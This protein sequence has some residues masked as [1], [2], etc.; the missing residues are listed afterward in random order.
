[1]YVELLNIFFL[2]SLV[3]FISYSLFFTTVDVPTELK[4]K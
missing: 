4:H 2:Y 3:H 1:M